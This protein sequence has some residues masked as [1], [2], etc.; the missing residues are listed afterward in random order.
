MAKI[1]YYATGPGWV[2]YR[3]GGVKFQ[4]GKLTKQEE[5]ES[6]KAMAP[7]KNFQMLAPS[8]RSRRTVD[9]GAAAPSQ[10]EQS[11]ASS[12]AAAAAAEPAPGS[13]PSKTKA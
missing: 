6:Y 11:S 2:Q 3:E 4:R 12:P 13:L 1:G 8:L 7:G 9:P 5:F 10:A